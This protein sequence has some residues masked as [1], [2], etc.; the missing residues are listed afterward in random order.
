MS[1]P[2]QNL[3]GLWLALAIYGLGTA[4]PGPSNMAIAATAATLGRRPALVLAA[5]VVSGSACWGLLAAAGLS[6]VLAGYAQAMALLKLIGGAYLLWLGWRAA[7]QAIHFPPSD[8]PRP[9]NERS[10]NSTSPGRLYLQGLAMHLTNPKVILSWLAIVTLALPAGAPASATLPV[11]AA[12]VTL[13]M[14]VFGSYAVVF[15][16][17]R[18]RHWLTRAGRWLHGLLALVFGVAGLK[19]LL[20]RT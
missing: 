7:R 15:S 11:V 18:A 10:E 8:G 16:T 1:D 3:T 2:A 5:G 17:E 4:T 13:G 12:C 19:L 20:A 14:G 9:D 6:S